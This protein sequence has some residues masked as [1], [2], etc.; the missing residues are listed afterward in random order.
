MPPDLPSARPGERRRAELVRIAIDVFGEAGFAG[1]RIDEIARRAGIR[2]PSVLYHFPDKASLYSASITSVVRDITRRV[3]ATEEAPTERLEAIADV[4][5]DF[6]IDRP[7]AARLL[8]RQMIDAEP[9]T[10]AE[11]DTH[12]RALLA[13]IQA[14]IDDHADPSAPKT[15]DA[16]E[17]S[18]ILSSTS[19]VWV[20]THSAVEGTLGLDTLAPHFVQRH[21]RMLCALTRQLVVATSEATEPDPP[22]ARPFSGETPV[23]RSRSFQRPR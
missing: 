12:L 11:S 14:A 13:S 21:R 5:V 2:R 22:K 1:G 18:L 9:V 17:F 15:I 10:D 7:S 8:L 6:V 16:S 3:L 4:W 23:Q 19:L 20:A